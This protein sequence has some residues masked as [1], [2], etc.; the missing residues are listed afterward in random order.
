MNMDNE[1]TTEYKNQWKSGDGGG[2]P[3]K[4]GMERHVWPSGN[5]EAV[6]TKAS[7]DKIFLRI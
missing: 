7:S 3:F 1:K 4:P 5:D 6:V 2:C